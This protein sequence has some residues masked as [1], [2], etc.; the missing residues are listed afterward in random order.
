MRAV[1]VPW[2][3]GGSRGA[4][5]EIARGYA[6]CSAVRR[7][8][9]NIFGDFLVGRAEC[10]M[11]GE[12]GYGGGG[13]VGWYLGENAG[14]GYGG[15]GV[16]GGRVWGGVLGDPVGTELSTI[17]SGQVPARYLHLGKL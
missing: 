6:S 14:V 5:R 2:L 1:F 17:G 10:G 8:C 13:L 3:S 7:H 9:G 11:V 15:G 12:E 16:W 4:L